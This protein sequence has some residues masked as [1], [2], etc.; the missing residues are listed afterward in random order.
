MHAVEFGKIASAAMACVGVT[1][2][3]QQLEGLLVA[4]PAPALH[5]HR[6][7]GLQ[8]EGCQ[9]GEN[10]GGGTRNFAGTVQVFHAHQPFVTA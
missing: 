8:S 1:G 10:V 4:V 6:Q 9:R 3:A 2:I 5:N 7:I